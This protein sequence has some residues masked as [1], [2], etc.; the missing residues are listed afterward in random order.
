VFIKNILM[1]FL[2]CVGNKKRLLVKRGA[3]VVSR[4]SPCPFLLRVGRWLAK[5]EMTRVGQTDGVAVAV[6]LDVSIVL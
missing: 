1:V 4:F 6:M 5:E 2:I 3:A